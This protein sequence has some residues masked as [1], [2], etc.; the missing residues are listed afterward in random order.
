MKKKFVS[1]RLDED[2]HEFIRKY[3]QSKRMTL[4]QV[5]VN[6]IFEF[7][8]KENKDVLHTKNYLQKEKRSMQNET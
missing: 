8:Q 6:L 7:Y 3:A 1:F 2:L 5:L 4:T